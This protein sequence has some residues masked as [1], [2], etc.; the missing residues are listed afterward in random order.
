MSRRG[1][2][3]R[4]ERLSVKVVDEVETGHDVV[5]GLD[6]LLESVPQ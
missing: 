6:V 4:A 5:R 3:T 2:A 1:V